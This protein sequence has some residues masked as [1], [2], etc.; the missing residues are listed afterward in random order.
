MLGEVK[1]FLFIVTLGFGNQIGRLSC[2]AGRYVRPNILNDFE[3]RLVISVGYRA[4]YDPDT[5]GI[6]LSRRS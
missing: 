1:L 3:E 6:E 5:G 2:R 4:T